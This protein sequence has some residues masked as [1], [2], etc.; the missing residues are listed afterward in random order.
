MNE[1][2]KLPEALQ[3]W[4]KGRKPSSQVFPGPLTKD[5]PLHVAM[6]SAEDSARNLAFEVGIELFC[7]RAG[8]DAAD[9]LAM[10]RV[11]EKCAG[12]PGA[13]A[14]NPMASPDPEQ[15]KQ[16][17]K[18]SW[19]DNTFRSDRPDEIERGRSGRS[20]SEFFYN[21]M[22]WADYF[23]GSNARHAKG[24]QNQ[25]KINASARTGTIAPELMQNATPQQ[26]A[27]ATQ[28]RRRS[29]EQMSETV[30]QQY[31]DEMWLN[32]GDVRGARREVARHGGRQGLKMLGLS[33]RL[34]GGAGATP[35]GS[36]GP[37]ASPPTPKPPQE[38]LQ[39]PAVP[40]QGLSGQ[41]ASVPPMN[42]PAPRAPQPQPQEAEPEVA[43]YVHSDALKAPSVPPAPS[44][45]I[46]QPGMPKPTQDS[47]YSPP[48]L[49]KPSP[50]ADRPDVL[51]PTGTKITGLK[52]WS[53]GPEVS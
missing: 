49:P 13:P 16:D 18:G 9:T 35:A 41:G 4:H 1:E 51:G 3:E 24:L 32:G 8:F 42:P 38:A 10:K 17:M 52:S 48:S 36:A 6:A 25:D 28:S 20:T 11:L 40:G 33:Q 46:P 47:V 22:A 31:D 43:P 14:P 53:V 23:G 27:L 37:V 44:E 29:M 2:A 39:T 26:K 34:Q 50:G 12:E 19:F 5:K 21:P 7:K 45:R 30:K 15:Q